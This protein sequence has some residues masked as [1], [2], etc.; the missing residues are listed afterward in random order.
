M[1]ICDAVT[2]NKCVIKGCIN[3]LFIC[4]TKIKQI[5]TDQIKNAFQF[6]Y[7]AMWYNTPL[8]SVKES[9]VTSSDA[10]LLQCHVN[11]QK[12]D[13]SPV[14]QNIFTKRRFHKIGLCKNR[15]GFDKINKMVDCRLKT[16]YLPLFRL[17]YKVNKHP[18]TKNKQKLLE[19]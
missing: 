3:M 4:S 9:Y 14:L 15:C 11:K 19:T 12:D 18:V 6:W 16:R 10:I 5:S 2:Q 7:N 1:S 13:F 17:H 8:T